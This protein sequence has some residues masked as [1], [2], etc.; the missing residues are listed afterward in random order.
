MCYIQEKDVLALKLKEALDLAKEEDWELEIF[1]TRPP[2]KIRTGQFISPDG[3]LTE[4]ETGWRVVRFI[5]LGPRKGV[6]I[7]VLGGE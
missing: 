7:V 1:P 5:R 4:A 2:V 6:F 3:C